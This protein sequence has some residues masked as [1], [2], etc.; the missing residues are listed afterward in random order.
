MADFSTNA[1]VPRVRTFPPELT[2]GL[3][4]PRRRGAQEQA[5]ENT[6]M[7]E[8]LEEAMDRQ[9]VDKA[10][11]VWS[12]LAETKL[13]GLPKEQAESD[14]GFK[15]ARGKLVPEERSAFA[16]AYDGTASAMKTRAGKELRSSYGNY[17]SRRHP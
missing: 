12:S 13:R 14:T 3:R 7:P 2:K 5:P 1:K 17:C 15:A 8:L 9:D 11:S 10:L 16:P 4:A 6:V